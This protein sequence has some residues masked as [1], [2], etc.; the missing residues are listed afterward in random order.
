MGADAFCKKKGCPFCGGAI[1]GTL[2][3]IKRP[4]GF[5]GWYNRKGNFFLCFLT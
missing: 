3:A 1:D 4:A 2:I 5:E